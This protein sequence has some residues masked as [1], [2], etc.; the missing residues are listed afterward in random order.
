MTE[1]PVALLPATEQLQ[2]EIKHLLISSLGLEDVAVEEIDTQA[3]LFG[4]GLGL[5]SIDA[6]EIGIALSKKY[7]VTLDPNSEDLRKHFASVE[8]LAAFIT[9]SRAAL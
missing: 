8:S 1:K 9:E 5:D 3:P 4:D 7:A 6:L 2:T